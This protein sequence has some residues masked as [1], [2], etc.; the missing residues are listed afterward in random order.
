VLI[1]GAKILGGMFDM[2]KWDEEKSVA[3]WSQRIS[4]DINH[5]SDLS[6]AMVSDF[7]RL[8]IWIS[9][10]R[11]QMLTCTI[12]EPILAE[13]AA[14]IMYPENGKKS[15][16]K[17]SL[18]QLSQTLLKG[19]VKGGY[20]GE[21]ATLILFILGLDQGVLSFKKPEDYFVTRIQTLRTFFSGLL[22][23]TIVNDLIEKWG[24]ELLEAKVFCTQF[25]HV[26]YT[27]NLK[28]LLEFFKR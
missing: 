10:S 5:L 22:N 16:I 25:I 12:S 27:P 14:M 4:F 26:S 2:D 3:L 11:E 18:I 24:N 17:T 8:C 13:A 9:T 1:A 19:I 20:R 6:T 23:P 28:I 21:L 7:M 15:R